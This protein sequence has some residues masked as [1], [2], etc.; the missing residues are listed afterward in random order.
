MDLY[1][2]FGD[3]G[4]RAT[5]TLSLSLHFVIILAKSHFSHFCTSHPPSA[6]SLQPDIN[7]QFFYEIEIKSQYKK[8]WRRYKIFRCFSQ[9]R[10]NIFCYD[11]WAVISVRL[12]SV[13][14]YWGVWKFSNLFQQQRWCYARYNGKWKYTRK[15]RWR[16]KK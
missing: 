10:R 15:R 7:S 2:T 4:S 6:Y 16:D 12:E 5:S 13:F 8:K 9:E 1:V 3:S 14:A 11:L